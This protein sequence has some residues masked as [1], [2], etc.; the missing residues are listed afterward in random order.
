MGFELWMV[1]AAIGI[2]CF[3]FI[4]ILSILVVL[5]PDKIF[6]VDDKSKGA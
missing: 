2:L 4:F 1:F 5:A 3:I 6:N